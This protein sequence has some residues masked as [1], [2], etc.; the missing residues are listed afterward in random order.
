[1]FAD[2]HLGLLSYVPR[3]L[4][5]LWHR[6]QDILTAYDLW[7][8][9]GGNVPGL[10]KFI[11]SPL[12]GPGLIGV[13]FLWAAMRWKAEAEGTPRRLMTAF[14]GL[15]WI[16]VGIAAFVMIAVLLFNEFLADSGAV[17][18]A[19]YVN[20]QKSERHLSD[21]PERATKLVEVFKAAPQF[22]NIRV[23]SVDSP[24]A[25]A[26]AR[27]FMVAFLSAG[28][29]VNGADLA[30]LQ[31]LGSPEVA[32]LFTPRLHGLLIAIR[33]GTAITGNV[34]AKRFAEQVISAGFDLTLMAW[35]GLPENEFKFVVGPK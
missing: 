9:A 31:T 27:E 22:D 5:I 30:N 1:M 15:G 4:G 10:V 18:F 2:R 33:P 26:Y 23:A 12:F 35:E 17:Q 20:A 25:N 21:N 7:T 6:V 34:D 24:E 19:E 16:L 13:G 8:M 28:Q 11:S 29:K 32:R 14:D 3:W